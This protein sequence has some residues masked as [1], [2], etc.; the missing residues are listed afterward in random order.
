MSRIVVKFL[1]LQQEN[2]V[3]SVNQFPKIG[4]GSLD[5]AKV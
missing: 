5:E 2:A 4:G 3:K 1:N